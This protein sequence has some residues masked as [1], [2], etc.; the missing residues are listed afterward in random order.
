MTKR[1]RFVTERHTERMKNP[2]SGTSINSV[3]RREQTLAEVELQRLRQFFAALKRC[4]ISA[5]GTTDEL[6]TC[7]DSEPVTPST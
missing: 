4:P 6:P 5:D 7:Q 3:N 2:E 1:L